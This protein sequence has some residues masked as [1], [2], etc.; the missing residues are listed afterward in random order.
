MEKIVIISRILDT[1]FPDVITDLIVKKLMVP[2]FRTS[3]FFEDGV[4][5]LINFIY[6]DTLEY[7]GVQGHLDSTK[8]IKYRKIVLDIINGQ[9]AYLSISDKDDEATNYIKYKNNIYTHYSI[10]YGAGGKFEMKISDT[11]VEELCSGIWD[12]C[13][14]LDDKIKLKN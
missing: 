7:L 10:C 8:V 9:T 11:Q 14:D 3:I 1:I 4:S 5:L 6:N 2:F 13:D 12:M